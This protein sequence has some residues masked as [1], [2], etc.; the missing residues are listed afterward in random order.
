MGNMGQRDCIP[1]D[2]L[3]A[4]LL[5][6]LPGQ[7]QNLPDD[8]ELAAVEEHLLWCEAC[9]TRAEAEDREIAALRAALITLKS[10]RKRKALGAAVKSS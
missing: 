5:G 8:P 3:E 2:T 1:E 7:Q 4:Y 10:S 9:Q 6:R